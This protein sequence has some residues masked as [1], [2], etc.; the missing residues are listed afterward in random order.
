MTPDDNIIRDSLAYKGTR[1]LTFSSIIKYGKNPLNKILME[2]IKKGEK[3]LGCPIEI[4]FALNI[5][6]S[7]IDEFCLLQIKPMTIEN[8]ND[9]ININKVRFTKSSF[10]YSENV[11]GD[12]TS[13]IIKHIV[14]IRYYVEF[15]LTIQLII[16]NCFETN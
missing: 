12:G 5:N 15:M 2:L 4:E 9:N 11:L 3:L 8:Y 16:R 10:C 1:I 6:D 14:Y 7:K 13:K